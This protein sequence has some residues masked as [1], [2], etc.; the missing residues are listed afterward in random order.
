MGWTK[1]ERAKRKI[2]KAIGALIDIQDLGLGNEDIKDILDKLE[3]LMYRF[4]G[5][6]VELI[7]KEE[8]ASS[9]S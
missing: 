6:W 7:E 3:G 4:D 8:Q 5:S 2:Y 9:G 1:E